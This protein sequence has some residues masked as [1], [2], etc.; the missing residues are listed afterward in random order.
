MNSG[1]YVN[2]PGKYRQAFLE[3]MVILV[4]KRI[5]TTI[6]CWAAC[7]DNYP[8]ELGFRTKNETEIPADSDIS[9]QIPND[10]IASP[11]D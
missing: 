11:C 8:W 10:L 4:T 7:E 5:M 6:D 9:R 3:P 2:S 1:F